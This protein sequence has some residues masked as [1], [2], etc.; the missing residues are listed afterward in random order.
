MHRETTM[1]WSM[2]ESTLNPWR[3]LVLVFLVFGSLVL[4]MLQSPIRQD[5]SYHAFVDARS[6]FGIPNFFNVISNLP[7]LF[8]GIAGVL[9]FRKRTAGASSLAWIIFFA[10]IGLV[11][12]G[13]AYYHW[14]PDSKSLLRDRLPMTAGFMGMFAALLG[15]FVDTR[16]TRYLLFPL[17]LTGLASVLVWY[18]FDDLRLYVWVQFMPL[19]VIPVL[20]LLYRKSYTHSWLIVVALMCYVLAKLLEAYDVPVFHFMQNEMGGHAI[21]H[22]IAALG[23]TVILW[24]LRVRRPLV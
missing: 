22:V 19:L 9:F 10:G 11:G 5:L 2:N 6:F 17:I 20:F 16:L 7:F 23:G 8:A 13:S 24:M 12:I 4:L 18:W 15:E 14:H 1:L 3:N 21:K